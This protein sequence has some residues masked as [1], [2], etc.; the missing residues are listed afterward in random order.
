MF[1]V[2]RTGGKQYRIE[3]GD[4]LKVEKLS[5]DPGTA[6]DLAEVLA[7]VGSEGIELGSPLVEGATVRATVLRTARG[8]KI[9]VFKKKRRKAYHKKQGHRQWYTLLRID[10][11]LT[12]GAEPETKEAEPARQE[13]AETRLENRAAE[14]SQTAAREVSGPE[15]GKPEKGIEK[16][17]KADKPKASKPKTKPVEGESAADKPGKKPRK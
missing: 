5:G 13:S 7:V 16:Q 3:P 6:I 17:A 8:R 15:A 1:A 11:I 12:A 14:K 4:Q 2:V 10:G 9:I